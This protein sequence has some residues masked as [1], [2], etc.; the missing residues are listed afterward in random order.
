MKILFLTTAHNSLSQRL[1]TAA[2]RSNGGASFDSSGEKSS[3]RSL[4]LMRRG[5]RGARIFLS[6]SKAPLFLPLGPEETLVR[7]G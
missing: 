7:T 3:R 6:E 1:L 2:A 4:K 5:T